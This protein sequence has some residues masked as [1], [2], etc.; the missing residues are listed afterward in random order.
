MMRSGR[1]SDGYDAVM[2]FDL[3]DTMYLERDYVESGLQAVGS[4]A[5]QQLGIMGLSSRM[6]RLFRSGSRGHIF[7]EALAEAG[8]GHSPELISRMLRV[9]RQHRPKI[10]LAADAS[11]FLA[12]RPPRTALAIITD[13]FLDAQKRKLRAL[14]LTTGQVDLAVCTDRWGRSHWKPAPRAFEHVQ[15]FF[16]L[17]AE[18]CT[19]VADNEEKDFGAPNQLGWRT[20][21]I[22][23]SERLHQKR[24]CPAVQ[25]CLEIETFD[26]L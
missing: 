9:Y 12:R 3:D 1:R 14:G 17:S 4:W 2:V 18:Q 20:V 11:R 10:A 15:S 22:K 25:V 21:H 6:L 7:D 5:E 24:L 19:Y 13:G 26:Q 23:R 16:G 8:E